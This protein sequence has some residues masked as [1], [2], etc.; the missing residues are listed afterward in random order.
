MF[1][2]GYSVLYS[3]HIGIFSF[4]RYSPLS[5]EALDAKNTCLLKMKVSENA[6]IVHYIRGAIRNLLKTF[7][8][9]YMHLPFLMH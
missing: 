3:L 8:C 5:T 6:A 7:D 1:R 4:F 2:K 9:D